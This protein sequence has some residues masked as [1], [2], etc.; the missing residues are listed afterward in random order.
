MSK[1]KE[2]P[3]K[4]AYS[5]DGL[6]TY[7]NGTEGTNEINGA[8]LCLANEIKEL[9]TK[10]EY[11]PLQIKEYLAGVK[12]QLLIERKVNSENYKGIETKK[13]DINNDK[14]ILEESISNLLNMFIIK[15]EGSKVRINL[16][17]NNG[18]LNV[19]PIYST[20]P[21]D[22]KIGIECQ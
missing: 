8:L 21:F 5:L 2:A 17:S 4:S 10:E 16:I 14:L 7:Y 12:E 19:I 6:I 18:S 11:T 13:E 22:I 15:H 3:R 20:E 9:K 1:I